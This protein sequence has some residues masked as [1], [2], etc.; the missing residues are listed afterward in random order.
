MVQLGWVGGF[1]QVR[2]AKIFMKTSKR[3][4]LSS[5]A[6]AYGE[7][8]DKL[9]Y[10]GI[11]YSNCTQSKTWQFSSDAYLKKNFVG[12]KYKIHS[13]WLMHSSGSPSWVGLHYY[14]SELEKSGL[15][16]KPS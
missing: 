2:C 5:L 4:Q 15:S 11:Y 1:H 13:L 6:I 8:V 7:F 16:F 9:F 3:G 14:S 10:L 12:G